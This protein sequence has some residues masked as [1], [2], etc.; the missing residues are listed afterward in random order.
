MQRDCGI[1]QLLVQVRGQCAVERSRAVRFGSGT[2]SRAT[3]MRRTTSAG[4][5]GALWAVEAAVV[6]CQL[7][8]AVET[9]CSQVAATA[10]EVGTV[11]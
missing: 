10:V 8:L 2:S 5:Y 9:G 1:L 6:L 4:L 11:A 3:Q 7:K